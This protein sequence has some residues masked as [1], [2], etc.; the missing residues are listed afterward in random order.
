MERRYPPNSTPRIWKPP[1]PNNRGL[2]VYQPKTYQYPTSSAPDHTA[3]A[4]QSHPARLT[5][6]RSQYVDR[7]TLAHFRHGCGI[8]LTTRS[9][10][11]I[12]SRRYQEMLTTPTV[13]WRES[14]SRSPNFKQ[15]VSLVCRATG[16]WKGD[17]WDQDRFFFRA[18]NCRVLSITI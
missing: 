3:L 10:S 4:G 6:P 11:H 13:G 16:S 8:V 5:P 12:S 7:A 1:P 2:V 14:E 9:T 15:S 17:S 18:S